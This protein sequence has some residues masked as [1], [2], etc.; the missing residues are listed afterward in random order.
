MARPRIEPVTAANIEAFCT[1]LHKNLNPALSIEALR[2]GLTRSW[3]VSAPNHGFVLMDGQEIVGGIGAI[4]AE[5]PLQG[6][7]T[8]ICN[9]TGWCVLESHRAQSMRLAMAIVAQEGWHF[10][11][12]SP[13]KV[14][15][16]MLR[17][18][19][20]QVL[21]EREVVLPNLPWLPA[22]W[23]PRVLQRPEH[24]EKVL[25][26]E[27]LQAYRDHRD[28]P[29]LGQIAVGTRSSW[30]HVVY[31][32][33]QYKGMP[34]ARIL[35]LDQPATFVRSWR[36]VGSHL[37]GRGMFSTHVEARR[38]GAGPM[39]WPS[40]VRSGFNPKMYR[41]D[42]LTSDQI[43]LLYSEAVALDL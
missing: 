25:A 15:G 35:H 13:T 14:V 20:F 34:A 43:D 8:R 18:L 10:T 1:F 16:A 2:A 11:D 28:F 38:L 39:P 27:A 3:H 9:I 17:F 12:L 19:K 26:G 24:I 4:Y 23:A 41:S 21:D 30:C 36:R 33:G 40:A 29:W 5:R 31:K 6:I 32:R 22:P 42:Q 7:P 37:L